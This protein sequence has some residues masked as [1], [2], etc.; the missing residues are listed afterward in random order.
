VVA[1]GPRRNLPLLRAWRGAPLLRV[2][3]GVAS[4]STELPVRIQPPTGHRRQIRAPEVV[5][6][7]IQSPAI[8]DPITCCCGCMDLATG[9]CMGVDP[10]TSSSGARD[11][12]WWATVLGGLFLFPKIIY[13]GGL[14]NSTTSVNS[15]TRGGCLTPPTS[16][17]RL[18]EAAGQ[19]PPLRP[20]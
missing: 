9:D 16:V 18:T 6:A 2:R 17:N 1:L 12:A 15:I 7:Q 19:P 14:L 8:A 5:G 10:D 13:G 20:Y 4:L 3:H 11:R